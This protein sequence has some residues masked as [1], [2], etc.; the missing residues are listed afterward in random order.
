MVKGA[1]N[2]RCI[3]YCFG[4][5]M[6]GGNADGGEGETEGGSAERGRE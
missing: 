6:R 2:I 4:N 3:G 1:K 5:G